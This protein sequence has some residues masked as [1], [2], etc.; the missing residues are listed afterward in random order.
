VVNRPSDYFPLTVERPC[1]TH[2]GIFAE[3]VRK[4]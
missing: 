4:Q 3:K 1:G 2:I